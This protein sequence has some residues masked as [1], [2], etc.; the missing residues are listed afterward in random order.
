MYEVVNKQHRNFKFWSRLVQCCLSCINSQMQ[1]ATCQKCDFE[2][3]CIFTYNDDRWT[4]WHQHYIK[5]TKIRHGQSAARN[6]GPVW[7]SNSRCVYLI[8]G[9]WCHSF[10]IISPKNTL[11]SLPPEWRVYSNWCTLLL[12]LLLCYVPYAVNMVAL[13]ATSATATVSSSKT[14]ATTNQQRT[15]TPK[16]KYIHYCIFPYN[17]ILTVDECYTYFGRIY[18][19]LGPSTAVNVSVSMRLLLL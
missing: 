16:P 7:R 5:Y 10:D 2:I 14:T 12:L 3:T 1:H 8:E 6:W 15:H 19:A 13:M 17:I 4:F 18:L 9:R 11:Q